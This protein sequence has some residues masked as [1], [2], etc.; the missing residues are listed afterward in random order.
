LKKTEIR[1]LK[2]G[3]KVK[4]QKIQRPTNR[5]FNISIPTPVADALEID[6]GEVLEWFIENKNTL[7]LKRTS[8]KQPIKFKNI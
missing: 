1:S 7:V 4:V 3:Y 5:S 8:P 2:V 6:K